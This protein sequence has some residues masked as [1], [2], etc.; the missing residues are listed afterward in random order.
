MSRDQAL[1]FCTNN[2]G[3]LMYWANKTEQDI[4]Q[5]FKIFL[6]FFNKIKKNLDEILTTIYQLFRYQRNAAG[7]D[8]LMFYIGLKRI[9]T[10]KQWQSNVSLI[11]I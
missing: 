7:N 8:T 9:N 4:L 3:T 1:T 5:S 10:I 2:N 6:S 11:I